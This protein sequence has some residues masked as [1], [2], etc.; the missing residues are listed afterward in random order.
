MYWLQQT[1]FTLKVNN[2]CFWSVLN[3]F[4]FQTM[5]T[6]GGSGNLLAT[7]PNNS[8]CYQFHLATVSN[9]STIT[10]PIHVSSVANTLT[11][12]YTSARKFSICYRQYVMVK[13]NPPGIHQSEH[14]HK[15]WH[16]KL[17]KQRVWQTEL[18]LCLK[19]TSVYL[20]TAPPSLS[21]LQR[22]TSIFYTHL[23]FG[24]TLLHLW[25]HPLDK[26]YHCST[27]LLLLFHRQQ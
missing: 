23:W 24:W 5:S 21:P 9:H 3:F 27:D 1:T 26:V 10:Q 22:A 8:L 7:K 20:T 18:K 2:L 19:R 16:T 12:L 14:Q 4:N 25:H 11:S 6:L 13:K 15:T 17:S